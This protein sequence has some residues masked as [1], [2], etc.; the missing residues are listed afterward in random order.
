MT[1]SPTPQPLDES[2]IDW[3]ATR[4]ALRRCIRAH[5][6]RCDALELDRLAQE[7]SIWVLRVARHCGVQKLQGLIAFVGRKMA[8]GEIRRRRRD[9]ARIVEWDERRDD[10]EGI[11]APPADDRGD[12]YSR[13]WFQMLEF[14]RSNNASCLELAELYLVQQ[15]WRKVADVL[16]KSG[17][18][19]R[20]QWSRCGKHFREWM[21]RDRDL[22]DEFFLPDA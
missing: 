4:A 19:V 14:F 7:G 2:E 17:E 16:G 8:E 21:E 20:K 22:M 10:I 6:G 1:T 13:L 18:A 15:S 5:L 11:P 3:N 9:R 12:R